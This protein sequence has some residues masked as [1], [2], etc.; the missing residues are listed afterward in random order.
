MDRL[1]ANASAGEVEIQFGVNRWVQVT[2][3]SSGGQAQI[4]TKRELARYL[5]GRGVFHREADEIAGQAWKGRPWSAGRP[6]ADAGEGLLGPASGAVL[7]V[8][9]VFLVASIA[10]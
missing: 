5:E 10:F 1:V 9:S 6:E 3:G 8:L 7:L 4:A 2:I